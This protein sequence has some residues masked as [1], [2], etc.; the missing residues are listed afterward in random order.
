MTPSSTEVPRLTWAEV[1]A[2]RLDRHGLSAPWPDAH[3]AD[4]AAVLCGA[5]AQVMSAA[6]L[7]IALRTTHLTRTDVRRALWTERSLVKT[8]GPRGTVYLLPTQDL[9]M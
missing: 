4:I 8:R 6:E 7:S 5:H 9:P 1:C 3:P 2:R